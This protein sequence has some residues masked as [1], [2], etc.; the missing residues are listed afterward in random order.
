[1]KTASDTAHDLATQYARGI[2][3]VRAPII[4][5]HDSRL[6]TRQATPAAW[7]EIC[8]TAYAKLPAGKSPYISAAKAAPAHIKDAHPA[9]WDK[10]IEHAS[11][12]IQTA[13]LWWARRRNL[14]TYKRLELVKSR[15]FKNRMILHMPCPTG[16]GTTLHEHLATDQVQDEAELTFSQ[17]VVDACVLRM[18]GH[19]MQHSPNQL[20]AL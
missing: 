8:E 9:A 12:A 10:L 6:K 7:C 18:A 14:P 11:L 15:L 20:A 5:R 19:F 16:C 4:S 17:D 13:N 1:M 2:W 3:W